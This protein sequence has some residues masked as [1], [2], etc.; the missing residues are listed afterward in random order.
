MRPRR[1]F[2]P[3][4]VGHL[5]LGFCVHEELTISHIPRPSDGRRFGPV[6]R[7]IVRTTDGRWLRPE[8]N[9]GRFVISDDVWRRFVAWPTGIC[10]SVNMPVEV[11]FEWGTGDFPFLVPAL[12]FHCTACMSLP[13]VP[14]L[15]SPDICVDDMEIKCDF[16]VMRVGGHMLPL[17]WRSCVLDFAFTQSLPFIE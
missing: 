8:T 2:V 12:P 5:A 15:L 10:C 14:E 7:C 11:W 13:F 9:N 17:F 1:Y 16:W 4:V 6:G 3:C